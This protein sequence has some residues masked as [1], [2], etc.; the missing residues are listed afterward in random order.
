[1]VRRQQE[2]KVAGQLRAWL[3]DVR[4]ERLRLEERLLAGGANAAQETRSDLE[5]ALL[6]LGRDK[7]AVEADVAVL[8]AQQQACHEFLARP[9]TRLT[10]QRRTL[11]RVL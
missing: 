6:C 10:S 8:R 5:A 2:A 11:L 1:V 4:G 3:D 7:A 9:C